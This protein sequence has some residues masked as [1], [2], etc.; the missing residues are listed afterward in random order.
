[1]RLVLNLFA[2]APRA[3]HVKTRLM[4]LL[5]ADGAAWAQARLLGHTLHLARSWQGA[6]PRRLLRLWADPDPNHPFFA[7][8]MPLS[9]LRTQ[10]AIDLGERLL[11]SCRE[12]LTEG[13]GVLLMGGDAVSLTPALLEEASQSLQ[14]HDAVMIPANDGGYLLLGVRQAQAELFREIPWGTD[15]VARL[16]RERLQRLGWSWRELPCQWDVDRPEDWQ[17]FCREQRFV[18]TP[19][20]LTGEAQ[21]LVC[22]DSPWGP[23]WLIGHDRGITGLSWSPVVGSRPAGDVLVRGVAWL[24]GYFSGAVA[25]LSVPLSLVGT[26]YQQRVWRYLCTIPPAT[27]QTYGQVARQAG[28]APRSVGQAVKANPLPILVPCHRVVA[29]AGLGGYSGWGGAD[30]KKILLTM[31]TA[32]EASR[33]N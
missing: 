21:T 10:P 30:T 18:A 33:F 11:L 15:Q 19:Q 3:G 2:K 28:G 24:A 5:G 4:P 26:P 27:T 12:G 17:H 9:C 14:S 23:L 16:T 22:H 29:A 8:H 20:L 31:E 6:A 13:E 25:P 1:M 7:A 32:G